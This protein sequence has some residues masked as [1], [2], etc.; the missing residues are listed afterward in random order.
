MEYAII[1]E[2][3]PQ[4]LVSEVNRHITM[5]WKPKGGVSVSKD[6]GMT[7][8]VSFCQAIVRKTKKNEN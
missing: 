1:F 8:P 5:G 2:G 6:T 7:R 3:D 4:K